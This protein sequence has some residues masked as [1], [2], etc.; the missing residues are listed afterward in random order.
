VKHN[1]IVLNRASQGIKRGDANP[2]D[3][4]IKFVVF[5]TTLD[6]ESVEEHFL[7]HLPKVNLTE[8]QQGVF[9][10]RFLG[11]FFVAAFAA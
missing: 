1:F 6:I 10:K 3:F 9:M 7:F 2:A 5:L 11:W 4:M 8:Q